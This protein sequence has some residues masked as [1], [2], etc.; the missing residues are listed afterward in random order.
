MV[1][2]NTLEANTLLDLLR[3]NRERSIVYLNGEHERSEVSFIE[4]ERRALAILFRLQQLGA[5]PGDKLIIFVN[6][7]EHFIE[8]F[9]GGV[10]GGIVPVPVALGIS[11][12]HRHKL[13]R[14][15]R[16]LG[17]P[18]LYTDAKTFER[19]RAF[20]IE[21]KEQDIFDRLHART[22][23]TDEQSTATQL[24]RPH[25]AVSDD[26]LFIQFSS[27]STSEP[28]GVVL[29]HRNVL[30]NCRGAILGTKFNQHDVGLSWMP[31]THDMGLVGM[32]FMMMAA[33]VHQYFMPTD[34][35]IRRP[36]LWMEFASR[37]R[38]TITTSPNFGLSHFLK[39]LGDRAV[40][41]WDLSSLR[42][43]FNG[44]EPISRQL[45]DEFV[46]RL[47]PA[48]LNRTA[49][50]PVYG[51]A[52]ASLAVSFP[53]LGSQY[54]SLTLD[55]HRLNV[56][57]QVVAALPGA[58]DAAEFVAVGNAISFCEVRLTDDHDK[59]VADGCV[60]HLHIRGDNVTRGYF[61]A[62][63]VNA[64]LITGDGWLR[65]GD[66]G[67]HANGELYITG[68]AKDI[69]FING[70]N[71]Y[72]HDLEAIAV[73]APGL[74]LNKVVV[75]GVSTQHSATDEVTAFVL[76]RGSVR[77]FQA[78]AKAVAALINEQAGLEVA[79]VVPVKRIPKT[80]S[81]KLQ[82]HLLVQSYLDGEFEAEM[83]ELAALNTVVSNA[84]ENST[85]KGSVA[86]RLQA[87]CDEV[88]ADRS[89]GLSDN[90]FDVGVSSLKLVAIHEKIDQAF[91]GLVDLTE[92]FDH[93]TIAELAAR[94][95]AKLV[96]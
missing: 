96:E 85:A 49:M 8:G 15:A 58:R 78:T 43:I 29:T 82:R 95:E 27:G 46:D 63:E 75:A 45:C 47:A 87:I 24:G 80:T 52:E 32:H 84:P 77:D 12:E 4:L 25:T 50:F 90:L 16:K 20:S 74:E 69:I 51:L 93:P 76:H 89:I 66:L 5:Q 19:L 23:L 57:E 3:H 34:L 81:G 33:G 61:D 48:K 68:R 21:A 6:D 60:G 70:Q 35:F 62:P 7:N 59:L 79:H 39:A 71:Y 14:I 88:L 40:S 31:L 86:Q 64:Q 94:L 72:P 10:I 55:R 38:A 9:W 54:H 92:I 28:K 73:R 30:A 91:P 65:T 67:L 41:D 11:D 26:P 56:G 1:D 22:L 17:A 2:V 13:L 83:R 36:R 42:L 18:F 44:A 37:I 53:K